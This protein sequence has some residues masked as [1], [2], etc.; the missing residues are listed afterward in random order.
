MS[1]VARLKA[2]LQSL[3]R[4]E[5]LDRD[6]DEELQSYLE[7]LRQEKV[8]GGM[9]PEKAHREARLGLGGI[10]QVKLP[11]RENRLGA[12]IDSFLQDVRYSFRALGRR[13]GFTVVAVM[14]LVLTSLAVGVVPALRVAAV[15]P[16]PQLKSGTH[17]AGRQSTRLRGGLV[18]LQV[19]ASIVLLVGGGLLLALFGAWPASRLI[20]QLL[21]ETQ[22]LDAATYASASLFLLAVALLACVLPAWHA[23]RVS[24]V[25]ALRT[26]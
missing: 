8:D 4:R 9:S 20:R 15:D 18:I 25:V 7:L 23:S 5:D 17:S 2:V 6:L 10:E 14:A 26:E 1:L 11:V 19:A 16:S 21:F 24:P 22:P 3:T 12:G 13:K